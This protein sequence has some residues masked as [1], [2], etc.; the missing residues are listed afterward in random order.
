MGGLCKSLELMPGISSKL[1]EGEHSLNC[2][3]ALSHDYQAKS[4]PIDES[5]GRWT[6]MVGNPHRM[7]FVGRMFKEQVL[8]NRMLQN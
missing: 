4:V 2:W 7:Y 8:I 1:D 5:N 6:A 3:L